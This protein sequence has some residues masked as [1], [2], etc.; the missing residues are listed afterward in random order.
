MW[1][2]FVPVAAAGENLIANGSFEEQGPNG[3]LHWTQS[4][5]AANGAHAPKSQATWPTVEG[6]RVLQLTGTS[7]TMSWTMVQSDPVAVTAGTDLLLS[8]RMRTEDLRREDRQYDNCNITVGFFDVQGK[9]VGMNRT[10]LISQ[11]QPWAIQT[12]RVSVP[13][14]ATTARVAA[15]LSK[16][17]T[18]WFDD[19]TLQVADALPWITARSEHFDFYWF[20]EAPVSESKQRE[21][22]Q[23]LAHASKMLG[24]TPPATRIA[25]YRYASKEQKGELTGNSGNGHVQGSAVHSLFATQEHEL[26]HVLTQPWGTPDT[27][28]FGEGIAV[29]VGGQW[30]NRPIDDYARDLLAAGKIPPLASIA[31]IADF[32]SQDDLMTYAVAGSFVG[33]LVRLKDMDAFRRVYVAGAPL[34]QR[35]KS[36][37][38]KDLATLDVEWRASLANR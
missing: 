27:G 23:D 16:S 37:Y 22:E 33:Y 4:E 18:A 30:Q 24:V 31:S 11:A 12:A 21:N 10:P 29:Y 2:V 20:A 14:G 3:A 8:G 6:S 15:F 38:G 5:G 25:F 26:V 1:L 9:R 35:L 13:A 19:I 32:R 34:D 7:A 36:E 28:L 17:G